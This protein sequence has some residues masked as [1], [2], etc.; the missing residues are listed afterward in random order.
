MTSS[1]LCQWIKKSL[2]CIRINYFAY[3]NLISIIQYLP[4]SMLGFLGLFLDNF[5]DL[6]TFEMNQSQYYNITTLVRYLYQMT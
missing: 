5:A 6:V 1:Y 2:N 4:N 3:L